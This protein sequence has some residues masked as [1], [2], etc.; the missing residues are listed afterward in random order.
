MARFG[1]LMACFCLPSAKPSRTPTGF[2]PAIYCRKTMLTRTRINQAHTYQENSMC[3]S[4][5]KGT[6]KSDSKQ[7]SYNF[8]NFSAVDINILFEAFGHR[9]RTGEP[10]SVTVLVSSGVRNLMVVVALFG[11]CP[12]H[13]M[14]R[15]PVSSVRDPYVLPFFPP[16]Q[17]SG[18][19][20][21]GHAGPLLFLA[22]M[23]PPSAHDHVMDSSSWA[24]Y[25][26]VGDLK[27][28]TH[29]HCPHGAIMD[30]L[31][32]QFIKIP[33]Y[34]WTEPPMPAGHN[35]STHHSPTRSSLRDDEDNPLC[36]KR[37]GDSRAERGTLRS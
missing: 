21:E 26:P 27:D 32:R 34:G 36:L 37:E 25:L 15:E 13:P 12:T 6:L 8:Y 30:F 19:N 7:M 5:P 24:G 28:C 31:M 4:A 14:G 33:P 2:E 9:G 10:D 16:A 1:N 17:R 23:P 3:P 20:D 29:N 35:S 11:R 18:T 22:A